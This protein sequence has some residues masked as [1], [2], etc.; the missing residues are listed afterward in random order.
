MGVNRLIG[1]NSEAISVATHNVS[2]KTAPHRA[3][4]SYAGASR[5]CET[6]AYRTPMSIT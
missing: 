4:T 5:D 6:M 2:A 3:S 1:M